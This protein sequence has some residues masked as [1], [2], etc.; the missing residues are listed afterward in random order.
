MTY[1][2][3]INQ[4]LEINQLNK[5]LK[6]VVIENK[7]PMMLGRVKCKVEGCLEAPDTESLV[8][9]KRAGGSAGGRRSNL[10]DF[11]VPPLGSVT[12]VEF[13]N[14]DIMTPTYTPHGDEVIDGQIDK[15]PVEDYPDTKCHI[16][17]DGSFGRRNQKQKYEEDYHVSGT[18]WQ[19]DKDGNLIV[20]IPKNV[21]IKIGGQ[22]CVSVQDLISILGNNN[23]GINISGETGIKSGATT[24]IESSGEISLQGPHIHLNDG[25]IYSTA[26][27][28]KNILNKAVEVVTNRVKDIVKMWQAIQ[29]KGQASK[30][31]AVEYGHN[32]KGTHKE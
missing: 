23:L 18:Y 27:N 30:Q 26:E 15:L 29:K 19:K 7:D 21:T 8:W 31:S 14:G 22:L 2:P 28:A 3:D 9:M 32:L 11:E 6:G 1:Q 20:S 16:H 24:G 12:T 13:K 25:V 5:P 10:G 4:P 17:E